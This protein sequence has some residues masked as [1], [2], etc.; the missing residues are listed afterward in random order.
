[1]YRKLTLAAILTILSTLLSTD[2][3]WASQLEKNSGPDGGN[4]V[5]TAFRA[6]HMTARSLASIL[7]ELRL[8][9]VKEGE[10]CSYTDKTS[11]ALF[12]RL[13]NEGRA[14]EITKFL[15]MADAPKKLT[16]KEKLDDM[17]VRVRVRI[18]LAQKKGKQEGQ[19]LEPE[20]A[21]ALSQVFGHETFEDL[22]SNYIIART[23]RSSSIE[24][25]TKT[26]LN[27][28]LVYKVEA[29]DD[30]RLDMEISINSD[31]PYKKDDGSIHLAKGKL[32]TV[33]IAQPGKEF[34]LGN[35]QVGGGKALIYAITVDKDK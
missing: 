4:F 6:N 25:F 22:G 29:R 23:N 33:I 24:F 20:I 32:N 9:Q 15:K 17:N 13:K 2:M 28:E 7:R 30:G 14:K 19:A 10:S 21:K 26:D 34:I 18:I 31:Y 27:L 5:T 35:T 16:E 1:M 11:R 8:L 3:I 12:L